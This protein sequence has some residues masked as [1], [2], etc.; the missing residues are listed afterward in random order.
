MA[1]AIEAV[2]ISTVLVTMSPYLAAAAGTPRI[3]GVEF[4]FGHPLGHAGDREEQMKVIRDALRALVEIKEPNTVVDLPYEWPEFELWIKA[5]HPPEPAPIMKYLRE[6]AR[7]RA[8]AKHRE[9]G[10]S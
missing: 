10:Q 3:V 1:R 6:Q 7:L 2:G 9:E 5:W 8:E 4:P